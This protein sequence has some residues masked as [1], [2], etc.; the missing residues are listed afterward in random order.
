MQAARY[1]APM[2]AAE[3]FSCTALGTWVTV[4]SE[5]LELIDAIRWGLAR[6]PSDLAIGGSLHLDA[7]VIDDAP[8][9]PAWPV[10]T[11]SS[12]PGTLEISCGSAKV[13]L[14]HHSEHADIVLPRSLCD[15]PDALALLAESVFT[16]LHVQARRL[17]A[18]H[19][20]VYRELHLSLHDDLDLRRRQAGLSRARHAMIDDVP[21]DQ[22]HARVDARWRALRALEVDRRNP[23][24][25]RLRIPVAATT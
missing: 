9:D 6:Y 25:T 16:S 7:V 15:V 12:T 22:H 10:V 2:P 20:A 19:A 24:P 8:G 1:G 11:A 14:H 5:S 13:V 18:V 21:L 4:S 3:V 17:H 23:N